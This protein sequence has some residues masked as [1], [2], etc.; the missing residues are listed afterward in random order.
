MSIWEMR[1]YYQRQSGKAVLQ[2]FAVR[3]DDHLQYQ[4]AER[5]LSY[6]ESQYTYYAHLC[7]EAEFNEQ[8]NMRD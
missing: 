1:D 4:S 8:V 6:F 2:K 3:S 7:K 5:T